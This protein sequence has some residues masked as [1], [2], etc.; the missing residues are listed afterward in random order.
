MLVPLKQLGHCTFKMEGKIVFEYLRKGHEYAVAFLLD[1]LTRFEDIKFDV[2]DCNLPRGAGGAPSGL[3]INLSELSLLRGLDS[4]ADLAPLVIAS[5]KGS[6]KKKKG[7]KSLHSFHSTLSRNHSLIPSMCH[8]RRSVDPATLFA[9]QPCN[10]HSHILRLPDSLFRG[11]SV[12]HL[13]HKL[14]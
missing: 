3:P 5:S 7:S 2:G 8:N 9:C 1:K 14:V 10:D 11:T 13:F 12:I 4:L 6:K